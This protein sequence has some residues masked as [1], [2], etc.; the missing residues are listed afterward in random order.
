M[1]YHAKGGVSMEHQYERKFSAQEEKVQE[2][3]RRR[4]RKRR[5]VAET[6]LMAVG[7]ATILV[8]LLRHVIIPLLV[9]LPS[10]LGGGA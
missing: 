9:F 10:V 7:A 2:A 8:L 5:S 6:L 1:L 4:L 3:P